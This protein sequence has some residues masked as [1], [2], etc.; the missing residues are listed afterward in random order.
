MV[1]KAVVWTL[2]TLAILALAGC[3]R[4]NREEP[5]EECQQYEAL[6][7]SCL[8]RDDKFAS[9]KAL[10]PKDEADRDRIR[11]LCSENLGRLR[12]ACR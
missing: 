2:F 1:R 5:V 8:H 10:I 4:S 12:R 11:R 7:S 6:R 9:Q 3:G